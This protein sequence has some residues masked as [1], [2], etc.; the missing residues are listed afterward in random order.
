MD[1]NNYFLGSVG[2]VDAIRMVDGKQEV[3]FVS[4]TMTDTGLNTTISAD[5]IRGGQGAPII[6]RFYHDANVEITLTDVM[7]KKAYVESQLGTHFEEDGASAYLSEEGKATAQGTFE[8][9]ET[10]INISA[11]CEATNPVVWY[12]KKGSND[13]SLVE[14]ELSGKVVS[15]LDPE[16]EYCFR[17]LAE[18]VSGAQKA[19]IY[20]G[21]VPE[22]LHLIITTPLFAGDACSASGG[23]IAGEVQYDIPRFRLNGGQDFAAAM[24]SNQT[25]NLSGVAL[26]STSG[27]DVDG[28]GALLYSMIVKLND[29][30]LAGPNG[31]YE[32]LEVLD[33]TLKVGERPIVY[34][35]D[36]A[37]RATLLSNALLNFKI[38][39][40]DA[41]TNGAFNAA[42]TVIIT[43][44][45]GSEFA[46]PQQVEVENA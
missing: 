32:S 40:A 7:F 18:S 3:A 20:A 45:D 46:E 22:E 28:K 1:N 6:T 31:R 41:L 17:Y 24:S 42:G 43:P 13:W 14:E 10:P 30:K 36:K 5:D 4:K 35:I 12:A 33:E 21:F 38:G 11:G 29:S 26:G 27:C 34:G 23:T 9:K 39:E 44:K 19:D 2:R 8:L 16:G 37:K 25:T 15:G